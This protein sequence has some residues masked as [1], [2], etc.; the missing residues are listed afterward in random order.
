M[1]EGVYPVT[2]EPT[3]VIYTVE[4]VE[5]I[6]EEY[7]EE[8]D[9][10][11]IYCQCLKT[12]RSLGANLP[13]VD[14]KDLKRNGTPT[15]GGVVIMKYGTVYH[16]AY[17]MYLFP[18]GFYVGEGNFKPCAYTERFIYWDDPAIQGFWS[19]KN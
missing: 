15:Q 11:S 1:V 7:I 5:E 12:S 3:P 9:E 19:L 18:G 6:L 4:E 10:E 2:I 17:I 13:R 16:T 8:V 14:A